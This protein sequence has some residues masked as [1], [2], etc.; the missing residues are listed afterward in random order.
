MPKKFKF[1]LE[2]ILKYR[3]NLQDNR[4]LVLHNTKLTLKTEEQKLSEIEHN[5]QETLENGKI[6]QPQEINL[7]KRKI[8]HEYVNQ[9]NDNITK[10]N[11]T[12]DNSKLKV[13][14]ATNDLNEETKRKKIL[15]KLREKHLEEFKIDLRRQEEKDGSEVAL[16]NSFFNNK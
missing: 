14:K 8:F 5:K 15:E 6:K 11:H 7:L 4:I 12:V 3:K 1:P 10:Q 13:Q 9:I 2:N 16:R